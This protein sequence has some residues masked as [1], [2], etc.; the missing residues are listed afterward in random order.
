VE[1]NQPTESEFKPKGGLGVEDLSNTITSI[2]IGLVVAG[3]LYAFRTGWSLP[4]SGS[5]RLAFIAFVVVGMAF[6]GVGIGHT[7][8]TVG[9]SNPLFMVGMGFGFVNLYIAYI[10]FTGG[11]FMFVHDYASA[12]MA[13]GGVM[14][15]KVITKVV[16]NLL[17]L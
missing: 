14:I 15:L 7:V 16:A 12:T 8:E 3:Y 1:D 6:C 11:Q 13:L 5:P 4:L 10:A 2:A 9:Y 17:Y